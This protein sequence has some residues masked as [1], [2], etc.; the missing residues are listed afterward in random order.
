MWMSYIEL[1]VL[2]KVVYEIVASITLFAW[3]SL[4]STNTVLL[5]TT[6]PMTSFQWCSELEYESSELAKQV[7]VK[8]T[9]S[10]IFSH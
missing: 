2:Y 3:G 7:R 4:G 1:I 10:D 9:G 8:V 5:L 6:V